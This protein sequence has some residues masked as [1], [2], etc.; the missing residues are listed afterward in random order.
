MIYK[1]FQTKTRVS[2]WLYDSKN[3]TLTLEG[4]IIGFDEYM[5]VV[6]DETFEVTTKN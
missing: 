1:F 5:N 4:R 3:N 2:I 6:L